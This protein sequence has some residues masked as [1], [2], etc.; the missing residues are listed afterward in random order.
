VDD[1]AI[2]GGGEVDDPQRPRRKSLHAP[3]PAVA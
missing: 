1:H 2:S 3:V